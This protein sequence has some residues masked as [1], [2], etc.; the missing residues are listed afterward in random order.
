[1]KLISIKSKQQKV[2][3]RIRREH[4]PV[5]HETIKKNYEG[6]PGSGLNPVGVGGTSW[7]SM[8]QDRRHTSCCC[9]FHVA[10]RISARFLSGILCHI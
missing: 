3:V 6:R 8:A 1:M 5:A 9:V 7:G 4:W 2:A 10:R